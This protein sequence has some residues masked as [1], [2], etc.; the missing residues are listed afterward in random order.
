ML[1]P[2]SGQDGTTWGPQKS[3]LMPK[4]FLPSAALWH[5][6]RNI[7]AVFFLTIIEFF[8][9]SVLFF[10]SVDS[11]YALMGVMQYFKTDL[12][13]KGLSRW[14]HVLENNLIS[15]LHLCV[16]LLFHTIKCF[17]HFIFTA[18]ILFSV[19]LVNHLNLKSAIKTSL[20][21]HF[22][23]YGWRKLTPNLLKRKKNLY[24]TLTS[25]TEKSWCW[26]VND[27][28]FFFMSNSNKLCKINFEWVKSWSCLKLS[29]KHLR[30]K[31]QLNHQRSPWHLPSR[32]LPFQVLA[33]NW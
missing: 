1:L 11:L 32:G 23:D 31:N 21:K 10:I 7:I 29:L 24:Y 27:M 6:Q 12:N 13:W 25:L 33:E 5:K 4:H 15:G 19:G 30:V 26:S 20:S 18:H 14:I 8:V 28:L 17:I 3:R 9:C 2:P 22:C 16:Q